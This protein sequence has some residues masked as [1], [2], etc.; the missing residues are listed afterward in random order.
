M[1]MHVEASIAVLRYNQIRLGSLPKSGIVTACQLNHD[2]QL[3]EVDMGSRRHSTRKI[4]Q[5]KNDEIVFTAVNKMV[6]DLLDR[7]S[8][9]KT[10]DSQSDI[11]SKLIK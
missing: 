6:Q 2:E 7:E 4:K 5:M 1:R 8:V 10:S 9:K 11:F 3:D